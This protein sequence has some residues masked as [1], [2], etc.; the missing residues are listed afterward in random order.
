MSFKY[1]STGSSIFLGVSSP[2]RYLIF[3]P[4]L[5]GAGPAGFN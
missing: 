4:K 3:T 5:A 2:F 1:Y